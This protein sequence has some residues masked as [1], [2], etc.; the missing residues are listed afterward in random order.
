MP[1]SKRSLVADGLRIHYLTAGE[2]VPLILLHGS[3]IDSGA[4]SYGPSIGAFAKRY[5]VI[6]PDWPGYGESEQPDY[7]LATADY[8]H[9]LGGFLAALNIERCHLLGFSMGGGVALGYALEQ[10]QRLKKLIL[11]SSYGLDARLQLPFLPYLALKAP[12][13]DFP[14]WAGLRYSK[15]LTALFLKTFIFAERRAVTK[16]L[17]DEVYEQLQVP[18]AEHAFM[19][20]LRGEMRPHRLSTSYAPRLAD[21]SVPTLLLHGVQDRII[22]V[23]RARAAA[24]QLPNARLELISRCGHWLPREKGETFRQEVLKFLER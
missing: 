13:L 2:G 6:A 12:R 9:L 22:P 14:V 10:P 11:V 20:W 4:L 5:L 3:A 21:L 19:A 16:E 17:V 24:R 7:P 8:I 23:A 15:G 18:A 1:A